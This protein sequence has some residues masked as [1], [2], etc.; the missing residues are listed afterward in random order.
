MSKKL[1]SFVAAIV[2]VSGS[3]YGQ[4]NL[5][6]AGGS[7]SPFS[8][9]LNQPVV[10]TITS[11]LAN[12]NGPAFVFKNVGSNPFGNNITPMTGTIT[13]SINNGAA[14]TVNM[15]NSG[16]AI[17]TITANDLYIFGALPGA[18]VGNVIRLNSGT[19][20]TTGNVP[21]LRPANGSYTTVITDG[22][23]VLSSTNGVAVVPEPQ[24]VALL[25]AGGLGLL[26]AV[27]RARRTA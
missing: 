20:T 26:V 17:G 19:L 2:L 23:G 9:T 5:T 22:S 12:G 13:F 4:A 27:R 11:A 6:F 8:L 16:F 7:G 3:A 14:Q 10:F 15:G 24:S 25:V 18:S 1:L 21:G